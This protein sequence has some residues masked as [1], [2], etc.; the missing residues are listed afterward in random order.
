MYPS[1]DSSASAL[2]SAE[3]SRSTKV[4]FFRERN[5]FAFVQKSQPGWE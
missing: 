5:S 3:T 2:S 4:T 1:R